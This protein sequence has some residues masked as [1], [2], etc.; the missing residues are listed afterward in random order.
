MSSLRARMAVIDDGRILLV[1]RSDVGAWEL[2][3]GGLEAGESV[4]QAAV[5]EIY[6]ETGLR[7]SITHLVGLYSL[8]GWGAEGAHVALFAARVVGGALRPQ[9]GETDELGFFDPDRLPAPIAWWHHQQIEDALQGTGGSVVRLQK[10]RSPDRTCWRRPR[11][12]DSV[13]EVVGHHLSGSTLAKTLG[14]P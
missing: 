13:L 14:S 12:E 1:K 10:V 9:P 3:S 4:A 7:V 5:R 6:E 11:P 8:P 2:P